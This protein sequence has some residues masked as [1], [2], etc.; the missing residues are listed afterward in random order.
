MTSITIKRLHH[1]MDANRKYKIYLDEKKVAKIEDERQER[2]ALKVGKH[3]LFI[4]SDYWC[5]SQQIEFEI[6]TDENKSFEIKGNG[7]W[8]KYFT[9]FS[10]AWLIPSLLIQRTNLFYLIY[11]FV[12]FI[13][14]FLLLSHIFY[15]KNKYISIME[16]E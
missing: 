8:V 16:I 1:D 2:I 11:L 3:S 7:S 13:S 15:Y 5:K 10:V 14:L 6:A 4:Q 12:I 9:T